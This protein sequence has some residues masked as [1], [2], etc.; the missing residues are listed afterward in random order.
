MVP[1]PLLENT[2]LILLMLCQLS[3]PEVRKVWGSYIFQKIKNFYFYHIKLQFV[4]QKIV[5]YVKLAKL[6][7]INSAILTFINASYFFF[8]PARV[9]HSVSRQSCF[10]SLPKI[11]P[12]T[13]I[14][15]LGRVKEACCQKG[16]KYCRLCSF[17]RFREWTLSISYMYIFSCSWHYWIVY[18][19]HNSFSEKAVNGHCYRFLFQ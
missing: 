6:V 14:P 5:N 4:I 15:M 13:F 7:K 12:W 3:S 1:S 16:Y 18:C 10:W 17:S 19:V 11:W 2:I 8:A 9:I